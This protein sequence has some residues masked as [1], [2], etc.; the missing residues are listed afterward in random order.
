MAQ[1]TPKADIVIDLTRPVEELQQ[2]I[3]LAT[4]GPE[5]HELLKQL[6]L[7]LGETLSKIEEAKAIENNNE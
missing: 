6:D 3:L 1:Y 7:W 4:Y 2:V 5:Q